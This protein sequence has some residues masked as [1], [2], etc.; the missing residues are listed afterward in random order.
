MFIDRIKEK[1]SKSKNI[2]FKKFIFENETFVWTFLGFGIANVLRLLSS[3][4]LTRIFLPEQFGIM[5]IL[6]SLMVG[7]ELLSDVGIQT[8]IIR[9]NDSKNT[10][11]FKSAW[12]LSVVRG[13]ILCGLLILFS[14]YF[15]NIFESDELQ[16][17]I[18][19]ISFV[20]ILK[21]FR[22][23]SLALHVKH[24]K[25]KV[26]TKLEL[27]TQVFA[28]ITTISLASYFESL[29]AFI[30]SMIF[31][32]IIFTL[33]T[34]YYLKGG[35][36][37]FLYSKRQ[38]NSLVKFGKWLFLASLLTF[39]TGQ[40]DRFL[41]GLYITKENLGIYHVASTLA[42]MPILLHG[43]LLSKVF[44]PAICE[45]LD[46]S[47]HEFNEL[48]NSLRIKVVSLT[49]PIAFVLSLF[50][51]DIISVLYDTNY[52]SAGKML[53]ILSVGTMLKISADSISP[54]LNA[55]GD[56]FRHMLYISLWAALVLISIIV[57]EY[58]YGLTGILIGM[59]ITPFFS[60]IWICFLAKKYVQINHLLSFVLTLI[61]FITL[62]LI[63][64]TL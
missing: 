29:W 42:A 31:T 13:F 51:N 5:A 2:N 25:V 57:G 27:T 43:A 55:R 48:F 11:F 8:S 62:I 60:L 54:V 39:I 1:I 14:G 58:L 37:G 21:G 10:A 20:F 46:L 56:S 26:L 61:S 28:L 18:M 47:H 40:G 17:Y 30:C 53:Q 36:N 38:I 6:I 22:S 23:T 44:F 3:L 52:E 41:L 45:K 4:I 32:E 9:N 64:W 19:V 12:T 34:Y 63:T 7:A 16:Q 59:A 35:I 49:F 15:S 24:R 50:G 33:S